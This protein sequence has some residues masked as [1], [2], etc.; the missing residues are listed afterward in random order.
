MVNYSHSLIQADTV[1]VFLQS[2]N[3]ATGGWFGVGLILYTLMGTY[4]IAKLFNP[5]AKDS[6]LVAMFATMMSSY[7]FSSLQII[8]DSIF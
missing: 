1:Q 7:Y 3:T 2:L 8:A 4:V 5:S 6:F